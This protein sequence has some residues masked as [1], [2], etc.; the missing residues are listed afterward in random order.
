MAEKNISGLC[1]KRA[2]IKI[3]QLNRLKERNALKL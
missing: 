3:R 1:R 2:K